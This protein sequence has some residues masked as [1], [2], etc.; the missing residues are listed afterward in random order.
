M[1]R[2][3]VIGLD[4]ADAELIDRWVASG[5]LPT[6]ASL[7][8]EGAWG[9]L[10]T[11]AEVM[12]VSGWPTMYTGVGPAHH[13]L[14]HAYQTRDGVRGVERADPSRYGAPPFW[15][16]LDRAGRRTVIMDAFMTVPI[17][18]FGGLQIQEY[19]T[20]TWFG[21]P[22]TRP[23]ALGREIAKRFGAYPAPEHLHVLE[24]PDPIWFRDRL[25]AGAGRKADVVRWLMR[26]QPWDALFVTLGEPHGAGHYLWHHDDRDYPATARRTDLAPHPLLDVYVAVDRAIERM[27]EAVTDDITVLVISADGMGPNHAGTQHIPEALHR[28]G[29]FHG[30]GVGE[31]SSAAGSGSRSTGLAARAR[32]LVPLAVRQAVSRCLPRRVHYRMSM[33]WVNDA[34]D[35]ERTRV[36]CIPNSNE[37]YLRVRREGRD[38]GGRETAATC[39]E[40]LALLDRV[41]TTLRNPD[42]AAIPAARVVRMDDVEGARRADL[43]DIVLSWEEPA[44]VGRRLSGDGIGEIEG[45]AGWETAPFYTG[46]HRPNAFVLARGPNVHPGSVIAGDILDFAPTALAL[47]DVALPDRYEGRPWTEVVG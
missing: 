45:K 30:A 23:P 47:L 43:P 33:K 34:V 24:P 31:A 1:S 22:E 32:R 38:P 9:R 39:A 13:G 18:P 5:D 26:E 12:H 35:W 8:A 17:Q 11:S 19:G 7:R 42:R 6:F 2:L 46:N 40:V 41:G 4:S 28:L 16:D 21:S 20:W 3:L 25:V 27:L 36:F 29:L 14:Y 44:A 15:V 10:R 37:A